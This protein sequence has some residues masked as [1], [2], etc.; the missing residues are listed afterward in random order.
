M[1]VD[2]YQQRSWELTF[3]P[4]RARIVTANCAEMSSFASPIMKYL[5][6]GQLA[7]E[8]KME[9]GEEGR[10]KERATGGGRGESN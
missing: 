5:N 4:F 9:R 10:K 3:A 2:A 6:Q 1:R 7:R 8:D